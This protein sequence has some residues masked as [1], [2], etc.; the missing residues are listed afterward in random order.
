MVLLLSRVFGFI[1]SPIFKIIQMW[2]RLVNFSLSSILSKKLSSS[3]RFCVI[4]PVSIVGYKY[5]KVHSVTAGPNLRIEVLEKYEEQT[6]CP[7]LVIGEHVSFNVN[8]HIGVINRIVIGNNVLIGSNVLITDHSHG[9]TDLK[10]LEGTHP[11]HRLL[12]SKGP[13]VI[14][15]DVWIGDNVSILP[16]VIIGKGCVIGCNT[17]VNKSVPPYSIVVGN[18]M[19]ILKAK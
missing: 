8:C 1:F 12:F 11:Q 2:N 4:R 9:T 5:I 13:V 16:N 15:D 10:T 18:P 19:R 17:V 14:E 7:L 3:G 6:F